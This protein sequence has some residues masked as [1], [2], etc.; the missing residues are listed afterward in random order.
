MK[1][2][3]FKSALGCAN[4]HSQLSQHSPYWQE[5]S[6][7][8]HDYSLHRQ[9][10]DE[11]RPPLHLVNVRIYHKDDPLIMKPATAEVMTAMP[12]KCRGI[13]QEYFLCNTI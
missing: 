12:Y 1:E 10:H 8:D 6:S 11:A 2:A 13:S 7:P 9:V 4:S 5:S 3:V